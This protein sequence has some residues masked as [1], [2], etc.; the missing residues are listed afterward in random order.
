MPILK[1][2]KLNKRFQTKKFKFAIVL[3]DGKLR[4]DISR[5]KSRKSAMKK[6]NRLLKFKLDK[7]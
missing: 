4:H 7:K 6:F 2:I 5:H 3:K 1:I